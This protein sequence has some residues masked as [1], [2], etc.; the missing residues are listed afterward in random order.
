[1]L[2]IETPSGGGFGKWSL[3][4]DRNLK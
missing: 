1:L 2:I 4:K 3:F